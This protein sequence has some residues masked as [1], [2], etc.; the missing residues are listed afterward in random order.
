MFFEEDFIEH[1][2]KKYGKRQQ[3]CREGSKGSLTSKIS[4]FG[5]GVPEKCTSELILGPYRGN[6]G[7]V[8]VIDAR[9]LI[10]SGVTT[11]E[12][13]CRS[14]KDQRHPRRYGI[15]SAAHFFHALGP[16]SVQP[17]ERETVQTLRSPS[18]VNIYRQPS[19]PE[20]RLPISRRQL[21]ASVSCAALTSGGSGIIG[22]V[23]RRRVILFWTP[24]YWYRPQAAAAAYRWHTWRIFVILKISYL[25][26]DVNFRMR[27]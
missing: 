13:N 14:L 26:P 15:S 10:E 6:K 20:L 12:D 21:T 27:N 8:D 9:K 5:F 16:W 22:A 2:E 18:A 7:Y 4:R 17:G 11:W 3:Q 24:E 19:S 23:A 1:M 25:L